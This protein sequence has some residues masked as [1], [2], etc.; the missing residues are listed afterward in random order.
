MCSFQYIDSFLLLMKVYFHLH[1][2][3][4]PLNFLLNLQYSPL[5]MQNTKLFYRPLVLGL[6]PFVDFKSLFLMLA[7]EAV[8]IYLDFIYTKIAK[9]LL[10]WVRLMIIYVYIFKLNNESLSLL[11]LMRY[12]RVENIFKMTN[13]AMS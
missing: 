2:Y 7:S 13:L 11:Q 4:L 1:I 3:T 9:L 5:N 10:M 6:R 12:Y 8:S